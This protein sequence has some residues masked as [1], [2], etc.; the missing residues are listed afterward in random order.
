MTPYTLSHGRVNVCKSENIFANVQSRKFLSSVVESLIFQILLKQLKLF[1]SK[2]PFSPDNS[3]NW[4]K[5]CLGNIKKHYSK[6]Y[7]E[8]QCKTEKVCIHRQ[9]IFGCDVNSIKQ[10]LL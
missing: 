10:Q 4:L 8:D 9:K 2:K 6:P 7:L 5:H 3:L 1:M